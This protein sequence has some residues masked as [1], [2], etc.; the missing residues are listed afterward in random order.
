MSFQT[1]GPSARY[2]TGS[3]VE[4]AVGVVIVRAGARRNA[5]TVSFF[6]GVAHHST[7]MWVSIET[8]CHTHELLRESAC[9]TFVT[10]HKHQGP[11]ALACGTVSGRDFDRS[12]EHTSE[13][14]SPMY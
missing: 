13:L 14:Q 6:S 4:S 9:F 7:S 1:D 8:S 10:L 3:V 11:I 12:E 5:M 2:L